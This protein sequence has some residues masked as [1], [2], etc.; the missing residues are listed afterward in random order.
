MKHISYT[1]F[2][3]F[4]AIIALSTLYLA[5]MEAPASPATPTLVPTPLPSAIPTLSPEPIQ[6]EVFNPS[7]VW[8][9]QVLTLCQEAKVY[10]RPDETATP[11]HTLPVDSTVTP[12]EWIPGWLMIEPARYIRDTTICDSDSVDWWALKRP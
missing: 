5:T 3:G 6:G 8:T 4:L 10:G 11:L 1:L 7:H 2:G 12:R 9:P